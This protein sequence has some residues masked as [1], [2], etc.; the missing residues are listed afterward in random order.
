MPSKKEKGKANQIN[1]SSDNNKNK[2]EQITFRIKKHIKSPVKTLTLSFIF[3]F[4]TMV[5]LS[6]NANYIP[7]YQM[8]NKA[9]LALCRNQCD[10]AIDCYLQA[11]AMVDYILEK[12]MRDFTRCVTIEK[13]DSLAYWI[14]TQCVKQ[15]VL[16]TSAFPSDTLFDKYKQ[17]PQ[18]KDCS[19]YEQ[20][21]I[22]SYIQ[23]Y[24]CPYK[25][26][27]DTL[28]VSDQAVR[29]RWNLF[30]RMFPKSNMAKKRHREMVIVDS[31]NQLLIDEYIQKAD[32]PNERNGCGNCVYLFLNGGCVMTHYDDTNFL[33]N[34]EYKAL[35]EGKLSP[36]C[37][38]RR[39][40][41]V[42]FI[43][44]LSDSDYRYGY[45]KKMKTTQE[46]EKVDKNRYDIGLPSVEEEKTINRW[47]YARYL[48]RQA[49]K[50]QS[51]K[52][53]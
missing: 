22:E 51:S 29:N 25:E 53:K 5:A 19:D 35:L 39:A 28:V 48:E 33:F 9:K 49:M 2:K 3:F 1:H 50:Q 36:E 13:N 18:W 32:F 31:C 47:E 26:L 6:Q 21:N 42:N 12:D 45:H 44:N 37:Y 40:S 24:T 43:F 8:V 14:M 46:K 27:F 23:K 7:Y 38:A 11:F 16:L 15:T 34:V 10:T 4:W 30:C 17:T 52:N 41:R 20:E